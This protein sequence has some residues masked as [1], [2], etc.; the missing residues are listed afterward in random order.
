LLKVM[1]HNLSEGVKVYTRNLMVYFNIKI[2]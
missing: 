2:F 1:M